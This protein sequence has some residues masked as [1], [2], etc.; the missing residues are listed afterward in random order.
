MA[1]DF[2]A[3]MEESY[4]SN[5]SEIPSPVYLITIGL[6]YPDKLKSLFTTLPVIENKGGYFT[7][8]SDGFFVFSD[9]KLMITSDES[10]AATLGSG[11]KL[12]EYKPASE[13]TLHCMEKLYQI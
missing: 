8:G 5:P 4:V 1:D 7:A 6:N 13:I 2:F 11:K 12:K 3:D 10:I 9:D